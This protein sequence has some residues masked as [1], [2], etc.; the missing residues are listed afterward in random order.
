MR[1]ESAF[2]LTGMEG[3]VDIQFHP[4][5]TQHMLFHGLGFHHWITQDSGRTFKV[6]LPCCLGIGLGHCRLLRLS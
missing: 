5:D 2:G 6:C 1:D 4:E 3:I